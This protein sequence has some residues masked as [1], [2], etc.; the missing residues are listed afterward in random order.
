MK[1]S[2]F[3][4]LTFVVFIGLIQ[5]I[6]ACA[7]KAPAVP[8]VPVSRA[9]DPKA[10]E[11]CDDNNFADQS[12]AKPVVYETVQQFKAQA[13]LARQR[14]DVAIA[15]LNTMTSQVNETRRS[16]N[17]SANNLGLTIQ[18]SVEAKARTVN[19][20]I[21][22][23]ISST[24]LLNPTIKS[25]NAS[26][27][28]LNDVVQ[29][30][31]AMLPLS[32]ELPV[33]K[34]LNESAHNITRTLKPFSMF[35]FHLLTVRLLNENTAVTDKIVLILKNVHTHLL[36]PVSNSLGVILRLTEPAEVRLDEIGE[37]IDSV[38]KTVSYERNG[39]I[40]HRNNPASIIATR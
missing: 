6:A 27:N 35:H 16:F 38:I 10:S 24:Q 29:S 7:P 1:I 3:Q 37:L 28:S 15:S 22:L 20:N 4:R 2:A 14:V 8:A 34:A 11:L 9:L 30:F 23:I 5:S 21:R 32:S 18:Q 12:N 39:P 17:V 13:N 25:I 31:Q 40:P 36:V 19:S 26:I 33:V